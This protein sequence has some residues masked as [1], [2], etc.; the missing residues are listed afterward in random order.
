MKQKRFMR[1]V[2]AAKALFF[3]RLCAACGCPLIVGSDVLCVACTINLPRT[4]FQ[5]V[6]D[7]DAEKL[8]WG[9]VHIEHV[10][11]FFYYRKG[12]DF[13]VVMHKL[14]YESRK[15]IGIALGRMVMSEL[16]DSVLMSD[17]DCIVPLPLHHKRQKYRGYNQSEMIA[18]GVSE[19]SG[20]PICVD[21]LERCKETESQT[22][23]SVYERW[24][25]V[26]G[27]FIL[28]KPELFSGKHILLID[29]VLT[30]GATCAACATAIL[31]V[32][33]TKV[34]I[35]TLAIAGR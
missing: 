7:N 3:P 18:M 2:E 17:I 8:F 28:K 31:A 16:K 14:K 6:L 27:V 19:I 10:V 24:G 34:S 23:K 4:G 13:S 35:L 29:D 11:P 30:T 32:K 33:E 12:S 15:D 22:R 25:N 20:L 1:W 9:K 26:E 5:S 21:G